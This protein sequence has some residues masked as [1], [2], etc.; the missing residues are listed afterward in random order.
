MGRH[1]GVNVLFNRNSKMV[2]AL[3]D[4]NAIEFSGQTK[5]WAGKVKSTLALAKSYA[6]N[7]EKTT[8]ANVKELL[9]LL[10]GYTRDAPQ[11]VYRELETFL[12]TFVKT[13]LDSIFATNTT[14]PDDTENYVSAESG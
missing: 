1:D 10:L 14:D 13:K 11:E 7:V 12:E 9:T 3:V 8:V 4:I 5:T 2:G 6:K